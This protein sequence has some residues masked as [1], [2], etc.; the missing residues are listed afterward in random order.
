MLGLAP[1]RVQPVPL[2][3][4]CWRALQMRCL[5]GKL[6]LPGRPH[7]QVRDRLSNAEL[8][9]LGRADR[10]TL[11]AL[12][13]MPG[14]LAEDGHP[15]MTSARMCLAPEVLATHPN[16]V[17]L[18]GLEDRLRGVRVVHNEARIGGVTHPLCRSARPPPIG[19]INAFLRRSSA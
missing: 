2:F 12:R 10:P 5:V 16:T 1:M 14:A 3:L 11:R 19:I 8:R 15:N 9:L 7:H 18:P 13:A 17:Y 6:L 4:Q